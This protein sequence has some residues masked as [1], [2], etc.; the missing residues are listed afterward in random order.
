MALN[1]STNSY[2]LEAELRVISSNYINF[3]SA[4]RS[5]YLLSA[6]DAAGRHFDVGLASN[7]ITINTDANS[8]PSNGVPFTNFNTTD[9]FHRYRLVIESAIGTLFIDGNPF[10]STPLGGPVSPNTNSVGFGDGA[11]V[12][13][14]ET[15]LRQFSFSTG[16]S[17][18][19]MLSAQLQSGN[20]V[21]FTYETTG[22]P[23]SFDVGLYRSADGMTYNPADQI[24][25]L[26]PVVPFPMGPQAPETV[27]LPTPWQPDPTKPFIVVVADPNHVITESDPNNNGKS[28][29]L[30]DI[31]ATQLGVNS[32]G[33]FVYFDVNRAAL[34]APST[35]AF[36]WSNND[37]LDAADVPAAGPIVISVGTT[38]GTHSEGVLAGDLLAAPPG[39]S[40]LLAAFDAENTVYESNENN[41]VV[42]TAVFL[43]PTVEV[44]VP[45]HPIMGQE[46]AV[47]VR[48]TNNASVPIAMTL[49][50]EERYISGVIWKQ[51]E[52]NHPPSRVIDLG[53]GQTALVTLG[54][55]KRRWEW[56]P[57][58]PPTLPSDTGQ[59][60]MQ[61]VAFALP[62]LLAEMLNLWNVMDHKKEH[63]ASGIYT[64]L[65]NAITVLTINNLVNQVAPV[66]RIDY[67]VTASYQQGNPITLV[68]PVT[69]EVSTQQQNHLRAHVLF[70]ILAERFQTGILPLD[71]LLKDVFEKLAKDEYK[72]AQRS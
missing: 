50:W 53:P 63:Y 25:N 55:L 30:P 7:G 29:A 59:Q 61:D 48:A 36:F 2:V 51:P 39:S 47:Q 67:T 69:L 28:V 20:T 44:V 38:V 6:A 52:L 5:G 15:E 65:A 17:D 56:L 4:Q 60:V 54:T 68:K 14:S 35:L 24:G 31:V 42:A 57:Q 32:A 58:H 11:G 62:N 21:Q 45:D 43:Q 16:G 33:V 71:M 12:G 3:G 23:G 70:F 49:E 13:I 64:S 9:T 26:H 72:L 22:N 19:H 8:S 1:F 37:T 34:S 18:I 46:Y 10:A 66:A 40:H 41:N 27:T